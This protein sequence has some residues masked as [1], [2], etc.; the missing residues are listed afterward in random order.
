MS[1]PWK[2]AIV[3][4]TS[5]PML[6]L[7]GLHTAFRGL[8]NVEVV[9][10]VDS[11]A[12]SLEEK[13]SYTEAKRHYRSCDE[14]L[15]E[16]SPDIVVICSRHPN[17][18]LK[19][20]EAV[21]EK[22]CHVYCEK[23]LAATLQ[24]VDRIIAVS[25]RTGIKIGMA[26]PARH[27]LAFRAM[28]K[29]IEMGEIGE[30]LTIHGRGKCDHRGGGEDL[31]VLGTHILDLM[32]FFFGQPV[33]VSAEITTRGCSVKVTDRSRTIEPIG[34]AAGDR[35]FAYFGFSGGVRGIFES[36]KGLYEPAKDFP[37][38]GVT[39]NGTKG[40][41]SLRFDDARERPLLISRQACGPEYGAHY[42][43]VPL[44]E[45]RV[46]PNAAPLDY[47]LCGR[48]D[49]PAAPMFL[50]SNRFAAWDLMQAIEEDRRPTSDVYDARTVLEMICGVYASHLAGGVR[51]TLPPADRVHPLC[52]S[53]SRPFTEQGCLPGNPSEFAL[54]EFPNNFSMKN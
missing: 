4:D 35:V 13:L 12:E 32:V 27:A 26:H 23:P 11:N 30:P 34:P 31:V 16:E 48:I 21:A 24:D 53:A 51:V 49:I 40:T 10:H 50:E 29:M 41:L 42:M 18:H 15:R 7:H 25:E 1:K 46:I 43:E 6:G 44:T 45:D 20:I 19:Q 36:Q 3:K 33:Y 28:K 5:K 8:P 17:D 14:M 2:V 22:G 9:A 52:K 37:W 39:V 54:S 47:S 38:M